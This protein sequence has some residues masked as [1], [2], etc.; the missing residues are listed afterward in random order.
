L[1]CDKRNDGWM[2]ADLNATMQLIV[3]KGR[4]LNSLNDWRSLSYVTRSRLFITYYLIHFKH[5]IFIK[6]K[7]A[8]IN[9]SQ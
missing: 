8:Q 9:R 5:N 7:H 2:E 1:Q 4:G 6:K 3:I